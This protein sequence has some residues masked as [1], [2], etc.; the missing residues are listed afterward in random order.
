M[1]AE[2]A[3]TSAVLTIDDSGK[4]WLSLG[5]DRNGFE[6]GVIESFWEDV[7]DLADKVL[8]GKD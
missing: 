5:Y 7:L 2:L 4:L 8:L 6:Q 1:V 3:Q